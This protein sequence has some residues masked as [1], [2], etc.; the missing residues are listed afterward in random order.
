VI[1]VA[2]RGP[3]SFTT[4]D[5]M[6]VEQ[7]GA[8]G[9]VTA[10]RGLRAHLDDEAVWVCAALTPEDAEAAADNSDKAFH[11]DTGYRVRMVRLDE[12]QHRRFYTVFANPMLWFIQHY[13]WNLSHAP[14]I[15]RNELEAFDDGYVP[16]NDAIADAVAEEVDRQ[17]GRVLVMI[18]DYHF[19]LVAPTVRE[20]CPDAVL[21]HFI[22]IPW[23]QPDAWRVLPTR[24][25][26]QL[27]HGL[28]ASDIVAFHTEQ[29]ARN[30][31]LTCQELLDLPVDMN[32]LTVRVDDRTVHVRWYPISIDADDLEAQ[33]AAPEVDAE[34][35]R[36][37]NGRREFLIV[38]VDRTDLSKNILR[39]FKAFDLLLDA[40]PE[41]S[42]R[43]TFLA[44]LQPSRQDV[45]E[46][47]EYVDRIRR[48][49]ADINLK[50]GNAEWQPIVLQI[51]DNL[52][53]AFAAYRQYDVLVVNPVYDGMN[54]VAK[55]GVLVNRRD[56]VLVLSENAGVHEEIGAFA[57][58]INPFDLSAQAN[59]LYE[60][61]TMPAGERRDRRQA[62]AEVVR[63]NDLSKWLR[64]Q[65][66]D[67]EQ[68]DAGD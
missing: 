59:A 17:G 18:H 41:L 20:R 31:V 49:A 4:M 24:I 22:H 30:F 28:L 27:L 56:G 33:A 66:D 7:R 2:H 68:L 58:T 55:E 25:R 62:C 29:Y 48:V 21:Q 8:G 65:L 61:I 43:V 38:R 1:V 51:A 16:V 53:G 6:R 12:E 45:D 37:E 14:D 9:L 26:E 15:T 11:V 34:E 36:I 50:H 57:L 19:Y 44:L 35:L 64:V 47:V 63:G 60:A 5:G 13:L 46:Y 32:Q 10:L 3:V 39:G 42:G 40:H 52:A 23:P 67:V 54:L